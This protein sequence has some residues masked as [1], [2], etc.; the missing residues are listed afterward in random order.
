MASKQLE[1]NYDAM[2]NKLE[3]TTI[4][5]IE[6]PLEVQVEEVLQQGGLPTQAKEGT[7]NYYGDVEDSPSQESPY[8]VHVDGE[9]ASQGTSTRKE[10]RN[11]SQFLR[12]L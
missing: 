4:F 9:Q 10:V 7:T 5:T 1:L 2:I 3:P 11:F 8:F 12:L 6:V